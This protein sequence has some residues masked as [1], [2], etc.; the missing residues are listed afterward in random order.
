LLLSAAELQTLDEMK[1]FFFLI[2]NGS[3]DLGIEQQNREGTGIGQ[4]AGA[5]TSTAAQATKFCLTKTFLPS[6]KLA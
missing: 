5:A 4:A 6:D 2:K 3:T 1:D